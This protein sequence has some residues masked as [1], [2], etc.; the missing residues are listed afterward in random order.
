MKCPNCDTSLR[1]DYRFCPTCGAKTQ[2][3]RITFRALLKDFVDRLFN[4]DNSVV[5]TFTG[6]L[7]RPEAVIDG[8]IKGLR[9]RYLNPIS[10]LGIALTLSGIIMFII[11]KFQSEAV[12]FTQA[13]QSVNPEFNRKWS[14]F[15]FD[16]NAF[17]F[18]L[19]LPVLVVPAFLLLNKVRYNLAEYFVALFYAMAQV[20]LVT[21]PISLIVILGYPEAYVSYSQPLLAVTLV[22]VLYVLYRINGFGKWAF[23][24]RSA[25][26]LILVV[27]GF[28]LLIIGL[29]LLLLALGYFNL[30]DFRPQA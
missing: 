9:K 3:R 29:M 17:F 16:Y 19:Y 30:E 15:V 24:W 23:T 6:L 18:F 4:L 7:I 26:Y 12:D 28:F 2:V 13:S 10:Y 11:Q 8:Y 25:V 20:S 5:R 14:E 1:L 22:Y 21:F 27:M